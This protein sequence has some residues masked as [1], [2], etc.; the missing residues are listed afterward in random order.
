RSEHQMTGECRLNGYLG[1]LGIP[2]F[3]NHYLVRIVSENGAK[4]SRKGKALFLIYRYLNNTFEQIFDRI[5]DGDYLLFAGMYFCKCG[6]KGGR[7]AG[8]CRTGNKHH[9]VRF[10]NHFSETF[11]LMLRHSED[12]ERQPFEIACNT[13]F[14]QDPDYSVF[15]KSARHDRNTEIDRLVVYPELKTAVLRH[16]SLGNV[17][18]AHYLEPGYDRPLEMHVDN[19]RRLVQNTVYPVLYDDPLH[20]GFDM[21]VARPSSK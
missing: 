9:A 12:I 18:L 1:G 15:S 14:I 21:Y 20:G 5:L 10:T 16:P 7:L 8:A 17:Q 3:T 2:D 11:Y 13:L 6:V 19:I 4:S